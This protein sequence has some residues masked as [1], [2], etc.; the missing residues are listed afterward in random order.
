MA[1]DA[2]RPAAGLLFHSDRGSQYASEEYRTA[3]AAHGMVTC[4]SGTGDCYDN[5][6]AESFFSTQEFEL[7]MNNDWHTRD[8][9]RRAISATS[10]S[11]TTGSAVTP[12]SGM[13]AR[14]CTKAGAGRSI[15]PITYASTKSGQDHSHFCA[16][17]I[18]HVQDM[19]W[20][21]PAS[22]EMWLLRHGI[23]RPNGVI[24]PACGGLFI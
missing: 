3:L 17:A 22:V 7:L 8:E 6:V 19:P 14:Q 16:R 18:V 24:W 5:A 15:G 4:M 20:Q 21:C 10:R 2:R 13:S 1:R 9:A 11:G 23:W 12:R